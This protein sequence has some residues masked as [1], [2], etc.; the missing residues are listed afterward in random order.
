MKLELIRENKLKITIKEEELSDFGVTAQTVNGNDQSARAMFFA[1]LKKAEAEVG[2]HCANSRLVVEAMPAQNDLV[3]YVTKVGNEA[4]QQLFRQISAKQESARKTPPEKRPAHCTGE[5][6]DF[7]S[8][9]E[10]C[11]AMTTYFGGTLYSMDG[12]YYIRVDSAMEGPISE[13][14]RI[15]EPEAAE[16]I[17]EH[18][19][20]IIPQRAFD[21]IRNNFR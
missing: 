14:A 7:D 17:Y 16:I 18:A 2:F 10:M 6:C 11:R 20:A 5:L 3:I 8:L 1:V 13:Y 12:K 15:I 9:V 19:K 21:I 4:E